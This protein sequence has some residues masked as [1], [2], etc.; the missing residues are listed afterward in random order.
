MRSAAHAFPVTPRSTRRLAWKVALGIMLSELLVLLPYYTAC[1]VIRI[2]NKG[3]LAAW[4]AH[5]DH[6][7]AR[8]RTVHLAAG[9]VSA[10]LYVAFWRIGS[11]A[12]LFEL[13]ASTG[14]VL[15]PQRQC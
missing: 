1:L 13:P 8:G 12:P 10:V 6:A 5:A 3:Q 4:A 11:S 15:H 7:G 14:P 2:I 9:A